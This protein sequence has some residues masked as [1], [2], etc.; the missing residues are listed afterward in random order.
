MGKY[1]VIHRKYITYRNA[2]TE[3]EDRAT[4]TTYM[5]KKLVKIGHMVLEMYVRIDTHTYRHTG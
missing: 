3:E 5:H 4:A 2:A 1:N